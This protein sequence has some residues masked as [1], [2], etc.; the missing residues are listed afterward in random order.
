MRPAAVFIHADERRL[1][2]V[3]TNLTDNAIKFT[4]IEGTITVALC[5]RRDSAVLAIAD[6]G[7][8]FAPSLSSRLFEKF[9]QAD[10][11][12]Q[13]DGLG[14]GL[15][16]VKNIVELHDGTITAHS[17]GPE[18]A[19]YLLCGYRPLPLIDHLPRR[20]HS[21]VAPTRAPKAR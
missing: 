3:M 20:R 17:T 7:C 13:R 11:T 1:Q 9:H 16:I 6:S 10:D 5:L 21:R 15:Y 14:L 12:T 8:G 19:R 4:S 2:Q 18:K